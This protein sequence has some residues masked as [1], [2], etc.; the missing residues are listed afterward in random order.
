MRYDNDINLQKLIALYSTGISDYLNCAASNLQSMQP[1]VMRKIPFIEKQ[2]CNQKETMSCDKVDAMF[3]AMKA[4]ASCLV[5]IENAGAFSSTKSKNRSLHLIC[6]QN[7]LKGL[8]NDKVKEKI[9]QFGKQADSQ[10]DKKLLEISFKLDDFYL[11]KHLIQNNIP[12][13]SKNYSSHPLAVLKHTRNRE[14]VELIE[15]LL[16]RKLE[17]Q[18]RMPQDAEIHHVQLTCNSLTNKYSLIVYVRRS[19]VYPFSQLD[20]MDIIWRTISFVNREGKIIA[21][22]LAEEFEHMHGKLPQIPGTVTDRLFELH[23]NL[24]MVTPCQIKS[25]NFGREHKVLIEP[26]IVLYCR[27]KGEIPLAEKEFPKELCGYK[28]DVREGVCSFGVGSPL[29]HGQPLFVQNIPHL[30][31]NVIGTLG[32]FVELDDNRKAILTCAHIFFTNSQL[33]CNKNLSADNKFV[34]SEDN[35]TT[36]PCGKVLKVRF[37]HG[38]SQQTSVDASLI[39][40]LEPFQPDFQLLPHTESQ[41]NPSGNN[42]NGSTYI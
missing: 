7:C 42:L 9:S 26:C 22:R 27:S 21:R 24:T 15:N 17:Q 2:E 18:S 14:G 16:Q 29:K 1:C 39:E 36:P 11:C 34:K 13:V 3:N 41:I 6:S 23:S 19:F 12:I 30:G 35:Q 40:L 32:G 8:I 10:I 25:I 37:Q 4:N 5:L 20:G 38:R 33:L 31:G 28:T